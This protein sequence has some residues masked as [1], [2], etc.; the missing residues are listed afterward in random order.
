MRAVKVPAERLSDVRRM[1]GQAGV[2]FSA[3]MAEEQGFAAVFVDEKDRAF[4]KDLCRM[5]RITDNRAGQEAEQSHDG[6]AGLIEMKRGTV[7]RVCT[8]EPADAARFSRAAAEEALEVVSTDPRDGL[9]SCLMSDEIPFEYVESCMLEGTGEAAEAWNVVSA[10]HSAA[11]VLTHEQ[12]DVLSSRFPD[13]LCACAGTDDGRVL[14]AVPFADRAAIESAAKGAEIKEVVYESELERRLFSIPMEPVHVL[15]PDSAEEHAK[16]IMER[17]GIRGTWDREPAAYVM[18]ERD[19]LKS[20]L[21]RVKFTPGP[22]RECIMPLK[23]AAVFREA[24]ARLGL[25]VREK[26]TGGSVR[27]TV[28]A[29]SAARANTVLREC[30]IGGS[31]CARDGAAVSR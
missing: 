12:M 14:A 15:V 30:G 6:D 26:E 17:H 1:A 27:F 23:E 10:G 3:S 9:L 11:A 25:R 19:S 18:A 31:F 7:F 4:I 22:E 28:P 29:A 13:I 16:S 8:L 21:N 5:F 24:A 20:R 2:K